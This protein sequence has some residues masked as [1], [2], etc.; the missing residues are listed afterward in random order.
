MSSRA[1]L[2]VA[3]FAAVLGL[4]VAACGGDGEEAEEPA[5]AETLPAGGG[6]GEVTELQLAADPGGALAYDATALEAPAGTVSLVLTNDSSV[7]HNVAIEAE[8]GTV[9]VEGEIFS[10]GGTRTTTAEL[11]AGTYTFFCSVPGHREAGME[12][13]LTVG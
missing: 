13:T 1:V 8:D 7:P 5:P 11:E 2:L 12:G 3:M 10:G 9:V 6:G 4:A